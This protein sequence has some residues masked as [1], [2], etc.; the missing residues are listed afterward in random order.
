MKYELQECIGSR[1]RGLSRKVDSIYRKYLEGTNITENQLSIMMAL[2][3]TGEIEQIEIGK[4]LILERSSLS[5]SL[6]RLIDQGFIQKKGAINRPVISLSKKG[7]QK[8]KTIMPAWERAMDE[9]LGTLDK[10]A[11]K[12]FNN[13]ELA[14]KQK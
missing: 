3:K 11:L 2:S 1:L 5:R 10:K 7:I 4:I 13:F 14:M 8:V 12:G 6:T 9:V